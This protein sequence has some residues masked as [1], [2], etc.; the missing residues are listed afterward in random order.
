MAKKKGGRKVGKPPPHC[1]AIL[2]AEKVIVEHHTG[3]MSLI[4]I[5][6]GFLIPQF[7]G[8]TRDMFAFL[9]LVGGIGEYDLVVEIHDLQENTV[10]ARATEIRATFPEKLQSQNIIIQ[11]PAINIVHQGLY[12]VVVLANGQEID[13]QQFG[14]IQLPVQ[15][16]DEGE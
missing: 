1:K 14:A 15:D 3:I 11:I 16:Q 9:Q 4:G 10:I 13:R 7:P 5:V 2:L 8:F 6:G 12:D